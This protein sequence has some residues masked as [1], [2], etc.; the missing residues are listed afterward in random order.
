MAFKGTASRSAK[1]IAEEIEEVGGELNAAT[2]LDSTAYYARI[3]KGDEGVALEMLADIL[4]NSSF[5]PADLDREREVIQQEIAPANDSPDDLAFDL[6]QAAAFPGQALGRNILGTPESVGALQAADLRS[7]L[8]QW[9]RPDAM[10]VAAAGAV[11][12]EK[13]V[14]HVEA[15][16]GGL[17]P[18]SA[19]EERPATYTGGV[20]ASDK[21]FEQSHVLIGYKS[22]SYLDDEFYTAQVFSGLFGGGMSSRLF[23]EIRE[24]RGLC[25]S[26]Y[27]TIWGLRD[28]GMLAVHAATGPKTIAQLTEVVTA[29]LRNIAEHGPSEKELLRAKAQ[30]KAGLMMA[31]ES[32]SVRAEQMGR[33]LMNYG[34]LLSADELVSRV[35]GIT[36][37]HVQS[38]AAGLS[39]APPTV[40]VVG[41][42]KKSLKQAEQVAAI[43]TKGSGAAL[44]KARA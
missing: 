14:R 21:P 25:Y 35:T 23:Q 41:S 7:F 29:E 38:Y 2:G 6:L 36:R 26:I 34:R 20:L 42:G 4:L 33:H 31:L 44:M 37:A 17:T 15:L 32:S 5:N 3:L 10:V 39:S 11:H 27:S 40:A 43:L 1:Q 19:G 28:V 8:D 30:L 9:Y 24:N 12:H 16:F 18:L 22:P 13:L